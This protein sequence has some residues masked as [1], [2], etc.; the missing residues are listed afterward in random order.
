MEHQTIIDERH[1]AV[2]CPRIRNRRSKVSHLPTCPDDDT[3]SPKNIMPFASEE[4]ASTAGYR[5]AGNCT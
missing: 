1:G 2:A 4:E 3:L 5:K